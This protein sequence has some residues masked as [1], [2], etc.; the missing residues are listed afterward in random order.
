MKRLLAIFS[1]I[2]FCIMATGQK[3]E[4]IRYQVIVRNMAGEVVAAKAV[5]VKFTLIE[6][7]ISDTAVYSERHKVTTDKNGLISLFIGNGD[8]K[9]GSFTSL[10]LS[11]GI[12]F[13]KVEIDV[14]GGT[15]YKDFGT[16]QIL[17]IPYAAIES[18]SEQASADV[19]EDELLVSRKYVG[20]YIDYRQTGPKDSNGPNLLWIK[21]SMEAKYG[22]IS[23]YGKKCKFSAGDRL[24][25]KRTFYS[26]GEVSGS[27]AYIIEND[28]SVF[29]RLTDFQ[30]DSKVTIENWFK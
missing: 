27:W 29:Y 26:P 4:F 7:S 18:T 17:S 22:K 13:L 5:S 8:E 25:I 3:P 1:T 16:T 12:Y 30:H 24:F 2:F 10:D 19:I 15:N 6:G 21:T 20:N 11:E 28:S 23:A 9:A 14:Y